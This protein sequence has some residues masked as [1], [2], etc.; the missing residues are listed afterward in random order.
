[1][2]TFARGLNNAVKI[3]DEGILERAV[4]VP[5]HHPYQFRQIITINFIPV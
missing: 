2:D 5:T 4:K 3:L 1:M